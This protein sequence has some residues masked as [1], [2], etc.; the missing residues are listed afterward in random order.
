MQLV[1]ISINQ[2]QLASGSIN[3]NQSAP[4]QNLSAPISINHNFF[5]RAFSKSHCHSLFWTGHVQTS[6]DHSDNVSQVTCLIDF[7]WRMLQKCLCHCIFIFKGVVWRETSLCMHMHCVPRIP[8]T[9]LHALIKY[10]CT[11]PSNYIVH[12]PEMMLH[13]LL[14]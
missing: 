13:T 2:N 11:H 12:T 3:Q 10:C 9:I 14:K 5:F 4:N 6:P 1:S 8:E 7:S